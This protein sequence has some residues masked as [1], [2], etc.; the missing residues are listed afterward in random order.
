MDREQPPEPP[1]GRASDLVA[2][3]APE[4]VSDGDRLAVVARLQDLAASGD[5]E[6]EQFTASLERVL[7]AGSQAELEESAAGLPSIVRLT[8]SSRKLTQ[9]A[10]IDAAIH[11]LE[12]GAGWQLGAE[13]TVKTNTAKVLV[14]LSLATWDARDVL[15]HLQTN[16]GKMTV[17][18]PRGVS[19]QIVS[20]KGR[21]ETD[22]LAPP[23]PG[24]PVL[25]VDAQANT[26]RIRFTHERPAPRQ[27]RLRKRRSGPNG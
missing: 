24:G 15:L 6:I 19:V 23:L 16:T 8:P 21:V 1:H 27:H 4:P 9:P 18:V 10:V 17:V 20:M 13:T 14:D 25:Q 3:T 7:A 11:K 2:G 22:E 26:G 12:L 5:L